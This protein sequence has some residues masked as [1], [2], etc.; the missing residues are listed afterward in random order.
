VT[1][2]RRRAWLR[3]AGAAALAPIVAPAIAAAPVRWPTVTL[4]D[5]RRVGAA[6][7]AGRA[8]VAVLWS[9]TCPFCAR[10]N[11]HVEKLHRA[12]LAAQKP[13]TV[14]TAATDRDPKL[15]AAYL[16][17]RGYTFPVTLDEAPLRALFTT[18]RVVPLTATVARDGRLR[19]VWPGEMFEEDVLALLDLAG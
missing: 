1:P 13:L 19:D 4:L 2:Q 10:H 11:P 16:K 14:L 9:T 15:V 8:V 12:A 7:L 5:G 18:R 6:E 17:Q 3:S